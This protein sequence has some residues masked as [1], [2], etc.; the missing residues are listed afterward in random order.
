M[1][2][3]IIMPVMI[4]FSL[5]FTD[6]AW[7]RPMARDRAKKTAPI[8]R[9]NPVAPK[10][11]GRATLR[12]I[13]DPTTIHVVKTG[14]IAEERPFRITAC[15]LNDGHIFV[16]W[17]AFADMAGQPHRG[18]AGRGARYNTQFQRRGVDMI[19]TLTRDSYFLESNNS[20]PLANGNILLAF[21]DK[22]DQRTGSGRGRYVLLSSE[23]RVIVGPITFCQ[24]DP[25]SISATSM[26]DGDAALI[27]YGDASSERYQGKFLIVDSSG[28][29]ITRPKPYTNKGD[30]TEVAAGTTWNGKAFV[31]YNC[32]ED[33]S[34]TLEVNV[35]GNISRW[36]RALFNYQTVTGLAVCP[37]FDKNTLVLCNRQGAAR[38]LLIGPDGKYIGG[39]KQFHP[40]QAHDMQ[41]TL[42]SNDNVFVSFTTPGEKAMCVVLDSTG[43][44]IKGPKALCEGYNVQPGLDTI[45]QTKLH[46]DMVAVVTQGYRKA[47]HNDDVT[48]WTVLK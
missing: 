24:R 4:T 21:N 16:G 25:K 19:Y 1:K 31:A 7:G 43:K 6:H 14:K 29:I 41:A 42:L 36:S 38:S 34:L 22:E 32:S 46:N 18:R 9:V 30:V 8:R 40:E 44:R 10:L 11:P 47:P 5:F 23:M 45:A 37:L 15:T 28:K 17:E 2:R 26:L 13:P 48:L 35:L 12:K 33:G 20:V 39:F 27:A 3:L